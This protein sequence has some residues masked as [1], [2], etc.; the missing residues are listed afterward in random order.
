MKR[1]R[2]CRFLRLAFFLLFVAIAAVWVRSF[3]TRDSVKGDT[4]NDLGEITRSYSIQSTCGTL[5][6]AVDFYTDP[7]KVF[8]AACKWSEYPAVDYD[9]NARYLCTHAEEIRH[10]VGWGAGACSEQYTWVAG[11]P[12]LLREFEWRDLRPP[13]DNVGDL[14]V[15]GLGYGFAIRYYYVA[16]APL[17]LIASGYFFSVRGMKRVRGK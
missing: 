11:R 4:T 9:T 15:G 3:W 5:S 10:G 13:V 14:P 1:L 2:K 16:I 8:P 17:F 12:H 7:L 6:I